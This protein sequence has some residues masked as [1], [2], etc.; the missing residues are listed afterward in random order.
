MAQ[1]FIPDTSPLLAY[2][3]CINCGAANGWVSAYSPREDG[4]DQTFRQAGNGNSTVAMN[5]TGESLLVDLVQQV[6]LADR[7]FERGYMDGSS[8]GLCCHLQHR[9]R[10][11]G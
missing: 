9:R 8:R 1:F 6:R 10:G 2:A 5:L 7:S 3:P 11:L 4:Y